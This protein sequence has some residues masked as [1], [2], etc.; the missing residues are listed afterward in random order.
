M[1]KYILA[2][3]VSFLLTFSSYAQKENDAKPLYTRAGFKIGMNYSTITGD[4]E[5]TDP[6][7]RVHMGA[8]IAFP[9]TNRFYIQTEVLYSAQGYTLD[10]AG[11]EEKISLNYLALPI[12]FKYNISTRIGIETG[13]QFSLLN[14]AR[15]STDDNSKEFANQFKS[16]DFSWALGAVYSLDSG[17]FFQARYIFGL[18]NFSDDTTIEMTNKNGVGQLSIGYLFKTKNN[19]RQESLQE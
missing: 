10:M 1:N 18:T 4:L 9:V 14:T 16:F 19:R 2:L 6:R 15:S 17:L 3:S 5:D 12:I 11:Q 8:V 7:L 13:P